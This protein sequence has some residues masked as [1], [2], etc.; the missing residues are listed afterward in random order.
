MKGGRGDHPGALR[1]PRNWVYS[2]KKG[3]TLKESQMPENGGDMAVFSCSQGQSPFIL[4]W[5]SEM[6]AY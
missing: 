4:S 5:F 2:L 6:T 3:V 1:Q